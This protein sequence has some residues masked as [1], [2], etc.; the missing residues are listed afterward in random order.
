MATS[1]RERLSRA[2]HFLDLTQQHSADRERFTIYFETFVVYARSVLH[3]LKNEVDAAGVFACFEPEWN[4]LAREAL[5][6]FFR[7]SRDIVLKEGGV[8]TE[9][10]A[11]Y[12][13]TLTATLP[14]GAGRDE[15]DLVS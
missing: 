15:A 13:V 12:A 3:V 6:Q 2:E 14:P 7:D 11:E 4:R 5:P 10:R 8:A 1:A 9:T